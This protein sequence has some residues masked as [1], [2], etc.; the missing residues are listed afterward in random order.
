MSITTRP[1]SSGSRPARFAEYR[2][3]LVFLR[4]HWWRMAG[5]V[6]ANVIGAALGAFSYTLLVPFLNTLV[7]PAESAL[8]GGGL[9]RDGSAL[10][11]RRVRRP[12]QSATV[13]GGGDHRH[14]DRRRDQERVRLARRPVRRVAPGIRHARHARR[15]LLAHAAAAAP[16]LPADEGRPGHL[17]DP[18]RHRSDEGA[19]HRAGDAH[20]A[21]HG[22]TS[23]RRSPCSSR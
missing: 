20:R 11:D 3:L 2:R 10:D 1:D 6:V 4:P 19:R 5:N 7:Q 13:V 16:L 12:E 17:E 15:R 22:A 8:E 18:V 9:G 23:S 14:H 21:E